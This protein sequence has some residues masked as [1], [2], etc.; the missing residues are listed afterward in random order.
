MARRRRFLTNRDLK[1]G[2]GLRFAWHRFPRL[3]VRVDHHFRTWIGRD[4][5]EKCERAHRQHPDFHKWTHFGMERYV[6]LEN[7]PVPGRSKDSCC[8]KTGK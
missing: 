7:F 3:R 6:L 8:G 4:A 1:R 5:T 2:R